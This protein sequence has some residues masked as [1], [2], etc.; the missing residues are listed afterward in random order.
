V[1]DV[2]LDIAAIGVPVCDPLNRVIASVS[3]SGIAS[4]YTPRRIVELAKT[5]KAAV[6]RIARHLRFDHPK[7]DSPDSS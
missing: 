3:L 4:T 2:S 1:Q 7:S 6:R 5:I